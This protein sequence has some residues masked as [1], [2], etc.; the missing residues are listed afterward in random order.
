MQ[1]GRFIWEELDG[2]YTVRGVWK[3]GHTVVEIESDRDSPFDTITEAIE[4]IENQEKK[5]D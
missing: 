1:E 4:Y 3:S 5:E 2:R